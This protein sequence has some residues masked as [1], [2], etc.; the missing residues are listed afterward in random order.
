[1][2]MPAWAPTVDYSTGDF[3]DEVPRRSPMRDDTR[4][5]DQRDEQQITCIRSGSDEYII[6]DRD[7]PSSWIQSDTVY[8]VPGT[9]AA[10][11]RT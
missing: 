6:Y 10:S 2:A 5:P 9:D 4:T 7:N 11:P 3:D 8:S 1:M